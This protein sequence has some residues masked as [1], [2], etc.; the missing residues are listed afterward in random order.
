MARR[1]DR[2]TNGAMTV[3]A[4]FTRTPNH[5]YMLGAKTAFDETTAYR[6][7]VTGPNRAV[8]FLRYNIPCGCAAANRV[9]SVRRA[10]LN[11]R[12]IRVTFFLLF[13]NPI[14]YTKRY[15]HPPTLFTR[16]AHDGNIHYTASN[17]GVLE[18]LN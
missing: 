13:C 1:V 18:N 16:N 15:L 5:G 2:T 6:I 8:I 17:R 12:Q 14:R 11:F 10:A 7:P 3:A 4:P 9:Y